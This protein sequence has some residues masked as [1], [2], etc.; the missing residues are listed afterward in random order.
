MANLRKLNNPF[1]IRRYPHQRWIGE[2]EHS[3]SFVHFSDIRYAVRAVSIIVNRYVNDYHLLTVSAIINRYAPLE[4][5][6]DTDSYVK[7]VYTLSRNFQSDPFFDHADI[8]LTPS[9]F[10]DDVHKATVLILCI[11]KIESSMSLTPSFV[12][13]IVSQYFYNGNTPF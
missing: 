12:Y 5:G 6:N 10:V 11:A 9:S 2:I 8:I 1:G 4:D 7:L 3:G 13:N